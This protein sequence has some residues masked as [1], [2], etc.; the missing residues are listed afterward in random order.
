MTLP[1]TIHAGFP[2]VAADLVARWREIPSTVASD[3][4][5]GRNVLDHRFKPLWPNARLCGPALP[6][7]TFPGQNPIVVKALEIAQPGDVVV[8]DAGDYCDHALIGGNMALWAARKGVGGLLCA[9]AVRDIAEIEAAA[10]PVIGLGV[11]PRAPGKGEGG[12]I[13]L[14]VSVGGVV[15]HPGDLVVGD[16]DGVVIVPREEAAEALERAVAREKKDA[17]TR[18]R[19]LAG[20]SMYRLQ[21]L[22]ELLG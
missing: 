1:A 5:G 10:F 11:C 22:H 13:G 4:L 15:V 19:V 17:E 16:R 18:A 20:A 3:A 14:P 12:S 21:G 6:V 2:R 7:K 8:V 9:G